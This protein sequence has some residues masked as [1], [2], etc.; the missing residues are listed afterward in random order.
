LLLVHGDRKTARNENV[1]TECVFDVSK[2]EYATERETL[3]SRRK[4]L[5]HTLGPIIVASKNTDL[6]IIE[7]NTNAGQIII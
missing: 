7:K 5:R 4:S 1:N 2:E 6:E 3:S